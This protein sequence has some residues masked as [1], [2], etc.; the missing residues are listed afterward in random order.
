[1]AK[2]ARMAGDEH[3]AGRADT[4]TRCLKETVGRSFNADGPGLRN[5]T[6]HLGWGRQTG[7]QDCQQHES[8]GTGSRSHNACTTVGLA[9]CAGPVA[10]SDG[11]VRAL[12][13]HSLT[14]FFFKVIRT[15]AIPS[16]VATPQDWTT[17]YKT[18][19][20]AA[21][22]LPPDRG[23]ATRSNVCHTGNLSPPNSSRNRALLHGHS[24]ES[25]ISL[26]FAG[27]LS[28]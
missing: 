3:I 19:R 5:R 1:M 27:L 16:T 8:G 14:A 6:W 7:R 9:R 18:A 10:F 21:S 11:T 2:V 4:D 26:A 17:F 15:Q 22:G 20:N 24:F 13:R 28:M 25:K 12:F 23:S